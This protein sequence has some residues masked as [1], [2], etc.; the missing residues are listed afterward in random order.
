MFLSL[1]EL[2]EPFKIIVIFNFRNEDTGIQRGEMIFQRPQG[3]INEVVE[4]PRSYN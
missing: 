3:W 4:E 1:L 2:K